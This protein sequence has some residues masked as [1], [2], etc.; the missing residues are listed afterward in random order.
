MFYYLSIFKSFWV[1]EM[2]DFKK[3]I[4]SSCIIKLFLNLIYFIFAILLVFS[5]IR[6]VFIVNTGFLQGALGENY[7]FSDIVRTLYNGIRYDGRLVA[8]TSIVYLLVYVFTPKTKR[9]LTTTILATIIS[10]IVILI[11]VINIGYYE[12]Y[13]DTFNAV[14]YGLIHDDQEALI[15]TAM[16]GEYNIIFRSLVVIISTIVFIYAYRFFGKKMLK[17]N[18]NSKVLSVILPLVSIYFIGVLM[19]STLSLKG[20]SINWLITPAQNSFLRKVTPGALYN[21]DLVVKNYSALKKGNFNTYSGGLSPRETVSTFYGKEF[22][23]NPI[24]LNDLMKK[25]VEYG[26]INKVDHVFVI[27][28]E[29]FS[30]WQFDDIFDEIG[31]TSGIK[32]L[33]KSEN[34]KKIN[35][36]IMN[37]DGTIGAIDVMITGLYNTDM[38]ITDMFGMIPEFSS[39]VKNMKNLGYNNYFYY[40]GSPAWRNLDRYTISQ[41]FDKI[42]SIGD[43]DSKERGV[44]GVSDSIGFDY[45]INKTIKN[46]DKPSF[47]MIMTTSYHPPYDVPLKKYNVP[48]DNI[49]K[50]L[51]ERFPHENRIKGM[52]ANVLGHAWYANNSIYNFIKEISEKLPNSLIVVTGDHFDR[53]Y[54]SPNRNLRITNEVPFFVYG[55]NVKDAKF[56]TEIGSQID[57]MPTIYELIAP[58][59]F[60]Y[61]SFGKPLMTLDKNKDFDKDRIVYGYTTIANKN[62]I[63]SINDEFMSLNDNIT[64]NSVQDIIDKSLLKRKAGLSLSYYIL[65]NGYDID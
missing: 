53:I 56:I 9:L 38:P 46:K 7:S 13:K 31:L 50:F 19:S 62:F 59:G 14:I 44:W 35:D 2:I 51:D 32:E 3:Y 6:I 47:N 48:V 55:K 65:Y 8:V 34:G 11:S 25:E 10:A 21:L 49:S 36:F 63:A 22:G 41:G 16:S 40:F 28:G 52:N 57:I 18:I 24:N 27:I 54:P 37:S 45:I 60:E 61:Y 23:L 33:L 42:Y 29:S 15:K 17:I 1:Y 58:K 26:S 5:I 20:G 30:N 43:F 12:I 64:K 4:S 39:S